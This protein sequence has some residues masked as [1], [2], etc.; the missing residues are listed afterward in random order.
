M[1]GF[2]EYCREAIKLAEVKK[3]EP[4]EGYSAKIPGFPGLV[5]FAPTR[6]EVMRELRSALEGWIELSLARGDGLPSLHTAEAVA[7]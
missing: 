4:D 3:L 7:G 6:A 5:A 1:N 2:G